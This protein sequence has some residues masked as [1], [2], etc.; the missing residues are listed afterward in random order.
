VLWYG[1][2]YVS[3]SDGRAADSSS[4]ESRP[5]I[6]S[7]Y[8]FALTPGICPLVNARIDG[9]RA[10]RWFDPSHALIVVVFIIR[11]RRGTL[12]SAARVTILGRRVLSLRL[13]RE[14]HI[15]ARSAQPWSVA[16]KAG[17][18]A[19]GV[20]DVGP[21]EPERVRRAGLTLLI[22]ALRARRCFKDQKK[23]ERCE[24]AG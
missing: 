17:R 16:S 18:D 19:V 11:P 21:A 4:G 6:L 20:R 8:G 3:G 1:S 14:K 23:S 24:A 13:R 12:I 22:R 10:S 15:I 2:L 9:Y 5:V 7:R